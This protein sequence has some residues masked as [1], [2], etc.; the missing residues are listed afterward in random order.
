MDLTSCPTLWYWLTVAL[1]VL[2]EN[3]ALIWLLFAIWPR[4]WNVEL[5]LRKLLTGAGEARPR[6]EAGTT[7]VM[8]DAELAAREQE[9]L[10]TSRKRASPASRG[11]RRS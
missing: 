11:A 9:L 5:S 4:L 8:S 7:A 6:A 2:L 1:C 10:S 3:A